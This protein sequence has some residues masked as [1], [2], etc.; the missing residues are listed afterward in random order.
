ML[1]EIEAVKRDEWFYDEEKK[2]FS[3]FVPVIYLVTVFGRNIKLFA[4]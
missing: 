2:Q 3:L 1:S 4:I